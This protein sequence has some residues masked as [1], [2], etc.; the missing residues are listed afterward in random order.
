MTVTPRVLAD[1]HR[2]LA[3]LRQGLAR[4]AASA[5]GRFLHTR[6]DQALEATMASAL[7]AGVVRRA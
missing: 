6:S 5:G 7:Q 2:A 1:Y 4:Q 3:E